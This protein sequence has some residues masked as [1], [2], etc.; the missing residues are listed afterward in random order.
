M[1]GPQKNL[2]ARDKLVLLQTPGPSVP[3]GD[4]NYTQSWT[5][6]APA[7]L[8]VSIETATAAN[9]ER[10]V[11]GTVIATATHIVSGPYHPGVTT[12][13][14]VVYNGRTFSVVSAVNVDLANRDTV[15]VCVEV[16][17]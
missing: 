1:I 15:M 8:W 9:L 12:K 5:D 14:R 16:V 10:L 11:A 6:L 4:G 13:S 2:A 17:P 3:D 7:T